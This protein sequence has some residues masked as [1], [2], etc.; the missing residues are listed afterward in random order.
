MDVL[1]L[2]VGE[3]TA[4]LS[5]DNDAYKRGIR[6][7]KSDLDGLARDAERQSTSVEN[8]TTR[9]VNHVGKSMRDTGKVAEREGERSGGLLAR[10]M[11][12]GV[13]RNSPLIVAGVAAALA[14]GA[15]AALAGATAMFAG[16]GIV[17]QS[18]SV[19]VRSAWSEAWD[20]IKAE[21]FDQ[22]RALEPVLVG[23]AD[24]VSRAFRDM[25]PVLR[26]TF[27]DAAPQM[28][29]FANG[30]LG[31]AQNALPGFARAVAQ[32][33]PVTEGLASLLEQIGTGLTGFFD[34]MSSRSPAAGQAFEALGGITANLLP[35]LGELL[36]QGA[37]LASIVLPPLA[38]ALGVV[39]DVVGVLGPLLPGVALGFAAMKSAQVAAG[40]LQTFAVQAQY[41]TIAATGSVRAGERVGGAMSK[42][43]DGVGRA[44][45]ALPVLGIVLGGIS[46][47]LNDATSEE[48]KWAQA[49]LA[50][51]SAAT[52]AYQEYESGT[53]W[54]QA[55]DEATG[56]AS[57]WDDA[58]VRADELRAAM[59][60]LA[61][62]QLDL[63][64]AVR[65]HGPTSSEAQAATEAYAR[66]Q[67]DAEAEASD[68][69]L[70]IDG[71]TTA[72]IEQA[73]Q[74][75]AA[76]DSGFAYRRSLDDLEDAQA[77]LNT[78]IAEHGPNS[79]AAQRAQLALEEQSFRTAYAFAQ[80]QADLSGL[81]EGTAQYDRFLQ[82]RLLTRLVELREAAGPEMR[83][84]IDQQIQALRDAG[85]T[86]DGVGTQAANATG[87][88]QTLGAQRP[89][90]VAYLNATPFFGGAA[91]L[92]SR[93]NALD[94]L[95]A[96]PLATLIPDVFNA[97]WWLN[98]T[99]RDRTS[100]VTQYVRQVLSGVPLFNADGGAIGR[101]GG[102]S[103][104]GPGGPRDDLIPALGPGGQQYRL[105]DG[106]HILDARDVALMG[107]QAGVYAFRAAL[108]SGRAQVVAPVGRAGGGS[109]ARGGEGM[110]YGQMAAAFAH[111]MPG[112]ALLSIGQYHE[113]AGGHPRDVAQELAYELRVGG[114]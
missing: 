56:L 38:A 81:E 53:H 82:E 60:P 30:L 15:P 37:E 6:D 11:Q 17:A 3:L 106:E 34:A 28:Q 110:D 113:A 14:A 18:Q 97:E 58:K 36:G 109:I 40:Y 76:I 64:N 8:R 89:N 72:M 83:G 90:P 54:G 7:A 23:L 85:V 46:S 27:E 78:A 74:A 12:H 26:S 103:V 108:N 5:V 75:L 31:M 77:D 70:A 43:A 25:G 20:D 66:A 1:A 42:M 61:R 96:T 21:A 92:A 86:I 87:Q 32:G 2:V 49:I 57:S 93:M 9:L 91:S 98:Y 16:V 79:E 114:R 80:Q 52:A 47:D 29:V 13:M 62:A 94:T 45:A 95:R 22:S 55:L 50:G 88:L 10:G 68:L 67:A 84:A 48:E 73:D 33:M 44:S 111:A 107:G 100:S 19:A 65:D 59:D 104:T 63:T 69:Q 99:A 35:V 112:M 4:H 101:A 51:G 102:G 24:Q 71:V 105:S 39:A 41:A